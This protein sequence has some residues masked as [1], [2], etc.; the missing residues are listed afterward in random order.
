MRSLETIVEKLKSLPPSERERAADFID[1]L[2][3]ARRTDRSVIL[4]QTAGALGHE[5]ADEIEAIVE[6]GCERVDPRD[7]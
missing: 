7:W 1:Q 5:Q 6:Q 4:R 2:D 3:S